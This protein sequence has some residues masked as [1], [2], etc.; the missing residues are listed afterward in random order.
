MSKAIKYG[1]VDVE[2]VKINST[3]V[4]EGSHHTAGLYYKN[5][6]SKTPFVVSAKVNGVVSDGTMYVLLDN[7][8][9]FQEFVD[10][11]D[12]KLLNVSKAKWNKR[13]WWGE[14]ES[15]TT[16]EDVQEMYRSLTDAVKFGSESRRKRPVL[17]LSIGDDFKM[18]TASGEEV[19]LAALRE[20]G[21][22]VTGTVVMKFKCMTLKKKRFGCTVSGLSMKQ[23]KEQ[24]EKQE[25]DSDYDDGDQNEWEAE[26]SE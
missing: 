6:S 26:E 11:L 18:K 22:E 3:L 13:H 15:V 12:E 14:S 23:A 9:E 25:E 17:K 2:N 4:E 16:E 7:N 10:I 1:N 8:A 20:T 21:Q 5:D 24:V 19:D